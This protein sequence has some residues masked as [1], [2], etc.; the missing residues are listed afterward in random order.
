MAQPMTDNERNS[1]L[2]RGVVIGG[3]VGGVFSLIDAKTRNQ[4]K[5]TAV[6][7]KSTSKSLLNGVKEN[8]SE[9]KEQMVSQF[10]QVTNVLKEVM[11]DAQKL[12]ERLNEDLFSKMGNIKEVSSDALS[13]VKGA[14]D[15]LKQI[16]YKLADAGSGLKEMAFLPGSEQESSNGTSSANG[17]SDSNTQMSGSS[18]STDL[19]GDI[20]SSDVNGKG[21]GNL[22]T[23]A[24]GNTSSKIESF[25]NESSLGKSDNSGQAEL[26]SSQSVESLAS[27]V[28]KN[29]SRNSKDE[30]A[31][32]KYNN[33]SGQHLYGGQETPNQ[34]K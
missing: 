27:K 2:M 15:D 19:A 24:A 7:L 34:K 11:G 17:S 16:G 4:L 8:P 3:L 23:E 5:E 9:M 14:K 28:T 10:T 6:D 29:S 32:M 31:G 25:G 26:S 30:S 22:K 13:T 12:Y 1:M 33:K 18:S 21:N 20:S